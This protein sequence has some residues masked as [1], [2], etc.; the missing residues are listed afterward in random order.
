MENLLEYITGGV[1][2]FTPISFIGLI[3]FTLIL[4]ALCRM[5]GSFGKF[6]R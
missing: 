4:E 1:N 2:E 3:V 6:G 5:I